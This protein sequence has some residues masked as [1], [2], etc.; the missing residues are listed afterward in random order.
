MVADGEGERRKRGV[1]ERSQKVVP[2]SSRRCGALWALF[3]WRC[4]KYL[5]DDALLLEDQ[6]DGPEPRKKDHTGGHR[7]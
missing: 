4:E 5:P 6:V 7:E 3:D 1:L 2:R